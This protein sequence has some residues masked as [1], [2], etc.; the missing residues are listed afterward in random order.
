L[1]QKYIIFIVFLLL[2]TINIFPKENLFRFKHYLNT[3]GLSQ[4]NVFSITQDNHNFIWIGTEDGLNRFDGYNFK[5]FKHIPED[6]TS[7]SD[8]KILILF[9]DSQGQLWIGTKFGGLNLYNE[10]SET[11]T[12]FK[13]NETDSTSI[14]SD[15]YIT[16]IC[17]DKY[18]RIWIGTEM[19]LNYYD[20]KIK[21]FT[22]VIIDTG[23]YRN[24]FIWCMCFDSEGFLW[25]GTS[26]GLFKVNIET[27]QN[28]AF[29][30]DIS[31]SAQLRSDSSVI[32][33]L[34]GNIIRSI[35][36]DSTGYLWIGTMEGLNRLDPQRE[37]FVQYRHHPSDT[38]TLICENI[39]AT[40]FDKSNRLWIGTVNGLDILDIAANR[41]V[42][43]INDP[44]NP[45]SISDKYIY[46]IFKDKNDLVWIGTIGEGINICDINRI[47]FEFHELTINPIQHSNDRD[48]LCFYED[49]NRILWIGTERNG[50]IRIDR[51]DDT[52]KNYIPN[53]TTDFASMDSTIHSICRDDSGVFW[54]GGRNKGL[55][56][57]EPKHETFTIIKSDS[58]SGKSD[59]IWSMWL[60]RNNMLWIGTEN[61]IMRLNISNQ[62]FT[63]FPIEK[64]HNNTTSSFV[65]VILEN[66]FDQTLW[67]GTYGGG[68]IHFNNSG[69]II[70]RYLADQT[71][72]LTLTNN[73]IL[74]LHFSDSLTL[75]IGTLNGGL[76]KLDIKTHQFERFSLQTGLPNNDILGIL[77]DSSGNLWLSTNDG[78][79]KFNTITNRMDNFDA[80]DGLLGYQFTE[81]S[82][83]QN[84]KGE[85][86]FG[87]SNGF[88]YFFPDSIQCRTLIQPTH[89]I[90]FKK[91]DKEVKFSQSILFT[92]TI[93]LSYKD[94]FFGF[95]FAN[96]N[97]LN[98]SKNQYA[99]QLI[100]FDEEWIYC[101][102]R[103]YATYTNLSGGEYIFN[104]KAT[105][106]GNQWNEAC[107]RIYVII[108][109]PFWEQTWFKIFSTMSMLVFI[110]LIHKRRLQRIEKQKRILEEKVILRTDELNR[111]K[112]ELET[113]NILLLKKNNL[114]EKL[115]S[116]I[117]SI[118]I[119]MD[120]QKLLQSILNATRII[121]GVEKASVLVYDKEADKYCF[122]ATLGWPLKKMQSIQL[123][124]FEAEYRYIQNS[125]IVFEDIYLIKQVQGRIAEEKMSFFELPKVMLIM[126]ILVKN[127]I[128][129]YLIFENMQNEKAFDNQDIELLK[130]LKEHILSAFIKTM[131][132]DEL[133]KL[134]EKKNTFL[135]MA[136]HDLRNPLSS[137]RGYIQLQMYMLK[138]DTFD[139]GKSMR[140]LER[141][142][143]IID[144]MSR[145]INELLDISAIESGKIQ[146]NLQ[147]QNYEKILKDAIEFHEQIAKQKNIEIKTHFHSP[148]PEIM[149]DADKI[150]EV[151][152]N[153]L[154]NAIKFTYPNGKVTVSCEIKECYLTT[155]ITDTGQ[156]LDESDMK[157]IFK[158]FEKL[159]ARP[160]AGETSTGLGLAIVK[161]IVELHHGNLQVNSQKNIGS[162]FSFFIPIQQSGKV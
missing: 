105:S 94:N 95:E 87:G 73:N 51:S 24:R 110:Y 90:N 47:K 107:S 152:D 132:M 34:C 77:G 160:T 139:K 140:D 72:P 133:K 66:P 123:T 32:Q 134:N 144:Q 36:R 101:G 22:R 17:E 27:F 129:A 145:L 96:L 136:A 135:G 23:K 155:H 64:I 92:D 62:Q 21:K 161:K 76:N 154:S 37:T 11:F 85:M 130:H 162:T 131:I 112:C 42:H 113:N 80:S 147:T 93:R 115:D 33:T 103:R 128:G 124:A 149:I 41:F 75:W 16:S 74:S 63:N 116:I 30:S 108:E 151:L 2:K 9:N 48:I 35:C 119:E 45:S 86:F 60:D 156:G 89:I 57:F 157:K 88:N 97:Y 12:R 118:N 56:R 50:L 127:R 52:Y 3:D 14:N 137:I 71:S 79:T 20:K 58:Q 8:N 15:K 122:E 46:S 44:T 83:Y 29:Y 84:S 117:R 4:N 141:T 54:L 143:A 5:I 111:K 120:F 126:R 55:I 7:L 99:Y 67:L 25:V 121:P 19:G 148:I 10:K 18:Q 6:T 153:L 61:G 104:V 78:I 81:S 43:Y 70:R 28:K 38:N 102:K 109:P 31:A 65:I 138:A 158:G 142:L 146:L 26:Y 114:L 53:H 40:Y 91:F 125:S 39:R 98:P 159:S 69:K 100:G 59:H 106:T 1:T 82:Y 49:D 68:L 13:Y 150:H